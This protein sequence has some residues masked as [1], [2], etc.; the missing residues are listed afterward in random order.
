MDAVIRIFFHLDVPRLTQLINKVISNRPPAS[1]TEAEVEGRL[2][3]N[4]R[5]VPLHEGPLGDHGLHFNHEVMHIDAGCFVCS[6]SARV[7]NLA[8]TEVGWR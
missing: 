3:I 5:L 4:P 8:L 7:E 1:R 6:R 2:S